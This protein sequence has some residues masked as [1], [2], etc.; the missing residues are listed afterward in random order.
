MDCDAK[1]VTRWVDISVGCCCPWSDAVVDATLLG[2]GAGRGKL[3][4]G[5]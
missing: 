2:F 5:M 1:H 3:E 4:F